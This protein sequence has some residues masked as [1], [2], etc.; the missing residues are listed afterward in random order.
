MHR[1]NKKQT[2]KHVPSWKYEEDEIFYSRKGDSKA[3]VY[4]LQ[5]RV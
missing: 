2:F 4:F 3:P 1:K 5:Q